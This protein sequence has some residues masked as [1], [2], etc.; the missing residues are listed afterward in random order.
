MTTSTA[1]PT[2]TQNADGTTTEYFDF[3]PTEESLVALTHELFET[4]WKRLRFGPCVPG[5]V[6]ELALTEKPQ[7]VSMSDGYLTVDT[8]P[9]HFHLCIGEHKN[10]TPEA[11]KLRRCTRAAFFVM[12]SAAGTGTSW[13]L[14]LWN[15]GGDQMITFFFPNANYDDNLKKL[16]APDASRLELWKSLR[17]KY[18]G[19]QG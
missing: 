18:A 12:K 7:R 2:I 1:A 4:H 19:V 9:W 17:A 10:T 13:G 15:G 6:F 11:A 8:G 5:A 14:R 16:P 3:A